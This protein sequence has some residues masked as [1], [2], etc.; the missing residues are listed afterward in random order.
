MDL[1]LKTVK[2]IRPKRAKGAAARRSNVKCNWWSVE[3]RSKTVTGRKMRGRE[4]PHSPGH[5]PLL[6][7]HHKSVYWPGKASW[8]FDRNPVSTSHNTAPV[9]IQ[10]TI[11]KLK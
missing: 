2:E 9:A 10:P 3:Y 6:G 4:A 1:E 7:L 8:D 5:H 11:S